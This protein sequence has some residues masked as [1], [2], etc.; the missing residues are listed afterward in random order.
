MPHQD[1]EIQEDVWAAVLYFSFYVNFPNVYGLWLSGVA[2][3]ARL[4][5]YGG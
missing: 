4:W 2:A 3:L 5:C 1:E